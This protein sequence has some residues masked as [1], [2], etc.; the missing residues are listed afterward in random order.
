MRYPFFHVNTHQRV[1]NVQDIFQVSSFSSSNSSSPVALAHEQWGIWKWFYHSITRHSISCIPLYIW[2]RRE[3]V[4]RW[5]FFGP[6]V[7][8]LGSL[9]A[10]G[11]VVKTSLQTL[12]KRKATGEKGPATELKPGTYTLSRS[13]SQFELGRWSFFSCRAFLLSSVCREVFTMFPPAHKEP[14]QT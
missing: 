10:G 7:L 6:F 14:R 1:K 5:C 11:N 12:L 4:D 9:W 13:F 2:E 3:V 8:R